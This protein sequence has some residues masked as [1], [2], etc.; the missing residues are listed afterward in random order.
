MSGGDG[1]LMGFARRLGMA[2]RREGID[3]F[4]GISAQARIEHGFLVLGK[5]R[6]RTWAMY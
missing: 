5:P 2:G 3:G 6:V 1:L 4:C